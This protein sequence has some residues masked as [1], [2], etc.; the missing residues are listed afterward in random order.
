MVYYVCN[1]CGYT[2]DRKQNLKTHLLR[3]NLCI[4][5][6][7]QIDRY[8][9]LVSYGFDEESKLYEKVHFGKKIGSK[10]MNSAENCY[11]SSD[12]IFIKDGK[13][14]CSYCDKTFAKKNI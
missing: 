14:K 6:I 7:N 9:L 11:D 4:P 12:E 10:S 3:K 1:R 13:L 2:T 5:K 8:N